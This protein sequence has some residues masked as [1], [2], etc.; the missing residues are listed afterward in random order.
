MSAVFGFNTNIPCNHVYAVHLSLSSL[1]VNPVFFYFL[2][3]CMAFIDCELT[4]FCV[5]LFINYPSTS[6]NILLISI[7]YLLSSLLNFMFTPFLNLIK[8]R[9]ATIYSTKGI[10]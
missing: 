6:C 9:I 1:C 5:F 8:V 3:F 7:D 10:A 4:S 2:N